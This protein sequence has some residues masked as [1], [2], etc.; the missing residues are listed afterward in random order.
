TATSST[1][2]ASDG[3]PCSPARG[4]DPWRGGRRALKPED[5]RREERRRRP[6]G[7]GGVWLRRA[8]GRDD[9]RA[10]GAVERLVEAVGARDEHLA[11]A[12]LEERN[13][14]LDLRSHAAGRELPVGEVAARLVGVEDVE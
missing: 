10:G 13:R 2:T 14:G 8:G 5:R 4:R 11:A 6:C 3:P 12:A 9:A 1:A 7:R